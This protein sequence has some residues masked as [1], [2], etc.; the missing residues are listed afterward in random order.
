LERN[1]AEAR[2]NGQVIKAF[3]AI[4]PNFPL[5][6]IYSE[7]QQLDFINFCERN[8]LVLIS[9]EDLQ[10]TILNKSKKFISMRS[11]VSK[12]NSKLELISLNSISYGDF[13]K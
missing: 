8:N 4:N 10:N 12:L 9:I 5:G 11:I 1:I 3:V 7:K 2:R 13:F 6:F